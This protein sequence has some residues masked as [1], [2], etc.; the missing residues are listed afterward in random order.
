ANDREIL[1]RLLDVAGATKELL[2]WL[3]VLRLFF[4]GLYFGPNVVNAM[5]ERDD[6][7]A[8]RPSRVVTLCKMLISAFARHSTTS[9]GTVVLSFGAVAE[10]VCGETVKKWCFRR[11]VGL[12]SRI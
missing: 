8:T 11:V 1:R 6:L 12:F 10:R 2:A 4:P 9:N 7:H 3:P 5:V